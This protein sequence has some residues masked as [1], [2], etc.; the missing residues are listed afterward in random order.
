[1]RELRFLLVSLWGLLVATFG[2]SQSVSAQTSSANEWTWVGG[3]STTGSTGYEATV[4][5]ILGT[6]SGGNTPGSRFDGVSWTDKNGNLWL[7][8]GE[9]SIGP[10]DIEEPNDLWEFSPSTN[11]WTWM[12]GG[13]PNKCVVNE[14]GNPGV[15]GILGTSAATNFPGSRNGAVAWS[16]LS[17]HL[18]L[19]GGDGFDA[20]GVVG[21][22]NDMWKFDTSTNRWTWMGG[23]STVPSADTGQPGVYGTIGVPA[24]GNNPGGRW[25]ASGWTD[26]KGNF[27]LFAG[28]GYDANGNNGSPNNLWEFNP[29]TNEW[30]WINGSSTVSANGNQ[31][32]IYGA[33]GTP[34]SGNIPGSRANAVNWSNSSDS[35]WL[36]GGN[37]LG[38]DSNSG[39]LNDMWQFNTST[40]VTVTATSGSL[41]HTTTFSL[42]VN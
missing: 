31:P 14:C 10:P 6:P 38:A 36:F 13:S 24:A 2:I 28:W 34:S 16:D 5:G 9:T 8:G 4:Y 35:L 33:L 39:Y 26:S 22:L 15:Y 32:G 23:S 25:M 37:G 1:M 30:A 3:S 21:V 11:E 42:T 18:W 20:N 17:G 41:S 7:F 19:Y 40:I 29:S 27:W 12:G